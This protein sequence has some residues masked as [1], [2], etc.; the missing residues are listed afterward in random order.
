MLGPYDILVI[1]LFRDGSELFD[2]V[3]EQI[4]T[5]PGVRHADTTLAVRRLK[6]DH[7]WAVSWAMA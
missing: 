7:R 1:T 5:L 2:L 4:M 3:N 6:Y